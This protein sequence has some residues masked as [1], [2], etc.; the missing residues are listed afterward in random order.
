MMEKFKVNPKSWHYK[1][2]KWQADLFESDFPKDF[3][4]Y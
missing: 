4:T 3:C 1:I 2:V